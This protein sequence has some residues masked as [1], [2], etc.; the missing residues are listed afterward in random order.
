MSDDE[1]KQEKT[2]VL[3]DLEETLSE[4]G[5]IRSKLSGVAEALKDF[6]EQLAQFAISSDGTH[7]V[8][9]SVPRNY[10]EAGQ[11]E[12]LMERLA[13]RRQNLAGLKGRTAMLYPSRRD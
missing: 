13:R 2:E 9:P 12:D 4:I 1:Q 6:S 3:Y 7:I 5:C 8:V 11:I 10:L